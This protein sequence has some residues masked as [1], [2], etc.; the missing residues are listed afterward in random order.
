MN[1]QALLFDFDGV[2]L[3]TE[4][5]IYQVWAQNFRDYG[6]ELT[7]EKYVQCIGSDFATWSPETYL[8]ELT[9]QTFDWPTI[10]DAGNQKIRGAVAELNP[11]PGVVDLLEWAETEGIRQ[12]VVSSSTH[13]WV[14]RWLEKHNLARFFEFTVCRGDAPRIKPAPDLYAEAVSR[15]DL[16][17][18]SCLVIEDSLNGLKSA[19]ATGCPVA[20][21]PC[22]VTAGIDFSAAELRFPDLPSLLQHLRVT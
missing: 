1:L 21:V 20:A 17:A 5:P 13:S 11:M 3:D 12:A 10:K 2:I 15:L 18:A 14:D 7:L 22:R 9:G 8:E 19:H 6:Q 16:P 4:W